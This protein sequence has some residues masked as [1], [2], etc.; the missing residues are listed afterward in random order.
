MGASSLPVGGHGAEVSRSFRFW[1]VACLVAGLV[2]FLLSSLERE[3]DRANELSANMILSQLGSALV[4]K[5]AEVRLDRSAQLKDYEGI[6]PFELLDHRWS[7]YK[8]SCKGIR[9]EPGDWCFQSPAK[10]MVS[11][12]QVSE[13]A[14]EKSSAQG[15]LIFTP[16]QPITLKGR[17]ARPGES[18]AWQVTTEFVDR[19]G[20]GL[21]DHSEPLTGLTLGPVELNGEAAAQV[22][23]VPQITG[24]TNEPG[25][26]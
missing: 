11:S 20:N 4:V 18:L 1:F 9:P 16:R 6:N 7:V 17:Q 15:W 14:M 10:G 8:G 12:E 2:W 5:G 3:I 24:K 21:R 19:N 23:A 22:P 13:S 25:R 26:G